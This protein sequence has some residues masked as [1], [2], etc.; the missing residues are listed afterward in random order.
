MPL[1]LQTWSYT[2]IER[3]DSASGYVAARD[4]HPRARVLQ[5]AWSSFNHEAT[6]TQHHVDISAVSQCAFVFQFYCCCACVTTAVGNFSACLCAGCGAGFRGRVK[7]GENLSKID[8]DVGIRYQSAV[9][10]ICA[11][12]TRHPVT[13]TYTMPPIHRIQF[14][15]RKML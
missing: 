4:N 15:C 7:S 14:S 3:G 10:V 12:V 1:K 11:C 5:R 8:D 13:Q 2:G 6:T 9:L